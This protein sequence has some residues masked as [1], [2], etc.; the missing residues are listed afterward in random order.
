VIADVRINPNVLR[1]ASHRRRARSC[2]VE[3]RRASTARAAG[4]TDAIA[5]ENSL[6]AA[7]T[8]AT[9]AAAPDRAAATPGLTPFVFVCLC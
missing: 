9:V 6:G 2:G 5:P 8:T 4:T 3:P 1:F 7:R